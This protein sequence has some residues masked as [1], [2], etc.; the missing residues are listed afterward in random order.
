M[1]Y[2]YTTYGTDPA[3][4]FTRSLTEC[5]RTLNT[6]M[7]YLV[8]ALRGKVANVA[9]EQIR[10]HTILERYCTS[11][12]QGGSLCPLFEPVKLAYA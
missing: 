8:P 1:S 7:S 3:S 5:C 2:S 11:T 10:T 4:I 6:D 12:V 9:T